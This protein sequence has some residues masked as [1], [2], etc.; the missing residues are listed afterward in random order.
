M[1]VYDRFMAARSESMPAGYL[2]PGKM[3]Q[4]VA[5]LRRH[6]IGVDHTTRP[7]RA[8]VLIFT[9][10]SVHSDS[11]FEGHKPVQVQG[12]W[13]S[14]S[15]DTLIPAGDFLVRTDQALGPLAAYLLE[16]ASEDGVVTW[17]LLD[18]DLRVGLP[19]PIVRIESPPL[20][21]LTAIP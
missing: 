1:P 10:D 3:T 20:V 16:P 9:P 4:V 17:N 19:Y 2:I 5:L 15:I 21:P 18:R 7:W 12:R 8:R 13:A 6:G 11:L 14:E